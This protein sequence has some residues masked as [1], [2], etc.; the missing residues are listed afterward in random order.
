MRNCFR[1]RIRHP[2]IE[3]VY[4]LEVFCLHVETICDAARRLEH[5]F[6]IVFVVQAKGTIGLFVV[7]SKQ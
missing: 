2:N 7:G 3:V 4:S 5:V 6:L 1:I